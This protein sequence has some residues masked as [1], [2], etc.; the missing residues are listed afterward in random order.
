MYKLVNNNVMKLL[1]LL[2]V[3]FILNL[4]S[5]IYCQGQEIDIQINRKGVAI[6]TVTW[7]VVENNTKFILQYS[8]NVNSTQWN[9]INE[10]YTYERSWPESKKEYSFNLNFDQPERYYRLKM[11]DSMSPHQLKWFATKLESNPRNSNYPDPELELSYNDDYVIIES[12]DIPTFEFVS[13]TPNALRAQDFRWE[14]PKYPNPAD[15]STQIP[16]LGTVAIT[17]SGMPIYGPNE[18]QHPDPF[19]DPYINGILDFCHG[20]TGGQGDYHFHFAPTCMIE[21]PDGVEEHYNIIGFALDGYPIIAHY[22]SLP[23]KE[24]AEAFDWQEIT[25]FEP[26]ADYKSSVIDN[27]QTSEYA[28]DN[29]SFNE[30]KLNRTLDECNGRE[31]GIKILS[32]GTKFNEKTFF[33][34]EYAY[35]ATAEFPYLIAKYKGTPNYPEENMGPGGG[36]GNGGG[37]SGGGGDIIANVNPS[38]GLS[39]ETLI[40]DIALNGNAQPPIPPQQIKPLSV[41]VGTINLKDLTRPTRT[42]I[43]GTL[44]IPEDAQKGLKDIII[45]FPGPPGVNNVS[46]TGEDKF[47]IQ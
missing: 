41:S 22:K 36:G 20:H 18:A 10:D 24:G 39:G 29:H 8:D 37:T 7:S 30:N 5:Y 31:L 27:G 17:T 26:H 21:A 42:S 1:R 47:E 23:N 13:T 32:D 12:N 28:W 11:E 40:L 33:N 38:S 35:F 3:T 34:F 45:I 44:I 14:I 16:L 19:G 6:L 4:A 15:Q 25:G 46:F 43:Q 9:T 2:S